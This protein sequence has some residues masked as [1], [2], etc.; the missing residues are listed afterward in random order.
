LR[1]STIL[2]LKESS[3]SVDHPALMRLMGVL[4]ITLDPKNDYAATILTT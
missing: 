3:S 2:P 4:K 1:T